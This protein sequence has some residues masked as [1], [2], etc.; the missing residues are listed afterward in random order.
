[1]IS[2]GKAFKNFWRGYVDFKGRATRAE[3]WWMVVWYAIIAMVFA[4][5]LSLAF[6]ADISMVS[7]VDATT[8]SAFDTF[9]SDHGIYGPLHTLL[10]GSPIMMIVL[11]VGMLVYLAMVI[12]GIALLIRRFRDAGLAT[13][14]AWGFWVLIIVFAAANSLNEV[15]ASGS[16]VT[17][18]IVFVVVVIK[19]VLTVLPSDALKGVKAIGRTN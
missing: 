1:M 4:V 7:S 10:S 5:L 3:Y 17:A 2:M 13:W 8:P 18:V 19:F 12:P 6:M 9:L 14:S 16:S 11:V 15:S